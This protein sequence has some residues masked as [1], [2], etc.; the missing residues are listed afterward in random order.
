[1]L[2]HE[3]TQCLRCEADFECKSGTI[4]LC[5]CSKIELSSAQLEYIHLRYD[6]CLCLE[7]LKIL[8]NEFNTLS[9]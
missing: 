6:G 8:Q 1:M 2:K 9:K 3:I 4:N 5:Q 7:C